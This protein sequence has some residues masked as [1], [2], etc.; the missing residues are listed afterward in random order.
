MIK[1]DVK[2]KRKKNNLFFKRKTFIPKRYPVLFLVVL[3]KKSRVEKMKEKKITKN[4]GYSWHSKRFV[5][6]LLRSRALNFSIEKKM[7]GL[8]AK[9]TF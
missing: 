6:K 4:S 8:W 1:V 9:G 3:S 2:E 7:T 5:G